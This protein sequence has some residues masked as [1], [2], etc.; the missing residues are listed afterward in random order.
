MLI[1]TDMFVPNL[2]WKEISIEKS[3]FSVI[4]IFVH[5]KYKSILFNFNPSMYFCNVYIKKALY[6]NGVTKNPK[7]LKVESD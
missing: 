7:I 1:L 4:Y 6:S 5:F 3:K 2:L